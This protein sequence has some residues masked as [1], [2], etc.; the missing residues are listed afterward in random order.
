MIKVNGKIFNCVLDA[1]EYRDILD[2]HFIKVVWTYL[3]KERA[4][5]DYR[6]V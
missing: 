4:T 6:R 3:S 1:I 5:N 2:A